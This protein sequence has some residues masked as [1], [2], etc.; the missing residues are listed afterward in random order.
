M[1]VGHITPLTYTHTRAH[2]PQRGRLMRGTDEFNAG[3]G[4]ILVL[5][6]YTGDFKSHYLTW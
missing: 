4:A 3:N 1:G 6:A 5:P 2:I